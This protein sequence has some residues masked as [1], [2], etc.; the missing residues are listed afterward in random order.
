MAKNSS[1]I[2]IE[3]TLDDLTFYKGKEGYL[4]RTKGGISKSRI[5]NDPAFI[6]TRENN[7]EFG[8]SA[9]AGKMLRRS[10]IDL[11]NNAKDDRVTSRLTQVMSRVK[12]NDLTSP[13]GKREVAIGLTNPAGR[14]V[15]NGFNFNANAPLDSVL[16]TEFALNTATGEISIPLFAPLQHVAIPQGATHVSLQSGFL[17]LDFA[18]GIKDLQLSNTVNLAFSGFGGAVTLTPAGVPVGSGNSLYFL[19]VTFFQEVNAV[20]YPLKNGAFNAL[21]LV[22]IL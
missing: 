7:A 21:Q 1:L 15:L 22:E 16:L 13:R 5:E 4:V 17:N 12:N 19:K 9:S 8:Q 10:I 3:G 14:Q 20:Q 2:K 11:L 18:T 6:R